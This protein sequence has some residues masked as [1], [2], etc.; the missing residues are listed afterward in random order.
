MSGSLLCFS[1]N[2]FESFFFA[3]VAGQRNPDKLAKG[4][5]QIRLEIEKSSMQEIDPTD[6][7]VMIESQVYFE[8]HRHSFLLYHTLTKSSQIIIT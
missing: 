3:T 7:Y 4:E 8:V 2:D 6:R 5:F 1:T